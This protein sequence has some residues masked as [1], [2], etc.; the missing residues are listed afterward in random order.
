MGKHLDRAEILLDLDKYDLAETALRQEIAE[1]PD[2]DLAYGSLARCLINQRK[3]GSATLETLEYALSLNAESDWLHY[4]FAVYWH[5]KGEFKQ[6]QQAIG[7]AIELDPNSEVYFDTLARILFDRGDDK[8]TTHNRRI[9]AIILIISRGALWPIAFWISSGGKG[10]WLRSYLQPVF[11]PLAKSLALNPEYLSAL[12]LQTQLLIATNRSDRALTSSL[13]ALEV[14]P[15]HH[16]A[17]KLHAQVLLKLG[18]YSAAVDH[19]QSSLRVDPSS[20]ESKVGLLEA[21]RSQY[22]VYP[23]VSITNWRGRLILTGVF[24]T[25]VAIGISM[26]W[27]NNEVIFTVFIYAVFLPAVAISFAAKSILNLYLQLNSKTKSLITNLISIR[28]AVIGNYIAGLT[29]AVLASSYTLIGLLILSDNRP[30]QAIIAVVIWVI[31]GVFVSTVTC[32]P[33]ID[34]CQ[35]RWRS[36]PVIYLLVICGLGLSNILTYLTNN[37]LKNLVLLFFL[38]VFLSPLLA[39]YSVKKSHLNS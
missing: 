24:L 39:I 16:T 20:T 29:I 34:Y 35:L 18:K 14:D 15:N 19:F 33:A 2:S 25:A 30:V 21:V 10:Y 7:V 36:T 32:L 26:T 3:L 13:N 28:T 12:N 6:A 5:M 11:I 9:L 37:H 1:N 23:W 8:F 38:L 22:W 4:L 27:F 31:A 17:H